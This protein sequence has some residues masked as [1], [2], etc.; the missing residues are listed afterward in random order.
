MTTPTGEYG[1]TMVG[2]SDSSGSPMI[3]V[4]CYQPPLES[5]YWIPG[6]TLQRRSSARISLMRGLSNLAHGAS[7]SFKP[8]SQILWWLFMLFEGS[9]FHDKQLT[10]CFQ[11]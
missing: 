5:T 3:I 1:K 11:V 7:A 8:K 10:R 2:R 9:L 6:Q 4:D